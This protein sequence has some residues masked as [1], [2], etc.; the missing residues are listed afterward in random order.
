[1]PNDD[2]R[3]TMTTT[4]TTST[5]M[6][7]TTVPA[8]APCHIAYLADSVGVDLLRNGLAKALGGVGC[9]IEWSRA[10]RGSRLVEGV[11]A[12]RA[13]TADVTGTDTVL[14]LQGYS[15]AKVNR[16]QFPSSLE[17]LMEAAGGRTV[18][19]SMYGPTI[20]CSYAYTETL[21]EANRLLQEATRRW[22]NLR[23]AD[24]PALLGGPPGVLG[25]RLPPPPRLRLGR[26][27]HVARRRGPPPRR[28]APATGRLTPAR[29]RRGARR[30]GATTV[31]VRAS[32]GGAEGGIG[33]VVRRAGALVVLLVLLAVAACGTSGS[34]DRATETVTGAWTGGPL[35]ASARAIRVGC[36]AAAGGPCAGE[37][38]TIGGCPVFPGDNWW[39][40]DISGYPVH[41]NSAGFLR[42]IAEVGGDFVHPDFGSNPSYGIPYVVVPASQ[43]AVPITYTVVG[44]RE[45]PGP[46]PHPAERPG[47]RGQRPPRPH[48]PA[49]H[50]PAVRAVRRP[51]DGSGL[52]GRLRGS[53]RPA[54]QRPAAGRLDL[55]RRRRAADPARPGPLR[56]GGQPGASAHALRVTFAA[57]Q[58]GYITPARHFAS[59][60][61]DPNLPPMGLRLRLRAGFDISGYTGAVTGGARSPAALRDAG[62]RQRVQ[63]VRRPGPPT[64]GGTTTT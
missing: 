33:M 46:V 59:D 64:R 27:G 4:T 52:G 44:Q 58:Q 28:A 9:T 47:G 42:R 19:W 56:R 18:V 57:T 61:S 60:S 24:Y 11:Q 29:P 32:C 13:A 20:G 38:P 26:G 50:V 21:A 8:P 16:G 53:L 49:G 43:P 40:T 3:T 54:L 22:P 51:A 6:V 55:G 41:P 31:A 35:Q 39:N 45:R 23:L 62:G 15:K 12:L 48:R 14:V 34:G 10:M 17:L 37:S 5:T 36:T 63:L 30:H 2:G 25:A 7:P 1:M